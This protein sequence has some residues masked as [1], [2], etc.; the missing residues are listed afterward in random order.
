MADTRTMLELLQAPTEGYEDAIVIPAILA[1]NFELKVG[2]LQL[3][4]SSQFHD[5]LTIIENKSKVR[6]SR[7]KLIVS[8]VSTTTSSSSHSPDIIALTDIVKEL[9]LM[10]KANQ[11]ASVKAVDEIC[12]TRGG[13][14]PYYE[15][16]ATDSN[17]FI[18]F[19]QPGNL[20]KEV[21]D[22]VLKETQIIVL[23]TKWGHPVFLL[24]MCKTIKTTI[25]GQTWKGT[26]GSGSLPS[27]TVANPRGDLK[28]FTT[29]SGVSY[30]GPMI[31]PTP[32]PLSK[33][34]ERETEVIKDKCLALADLGA[35]I[36]LMPLSVWKKL[37]LPELTPTRM[38]L[39]LADRSVAHPK[40]LIDVHGEELTLRVNDEAI[41]FKVGHTSRY[42][43]NYYDEMVHQVNVIDVA[44]E[45]YAQEVLR[46]LDSSTS[47]NPT[48]SNPIIAS[49]SPSF[50]PF[51]GGDFIL[52]EIEACL[53]NDSIPSGIDDA[54]FDP[55]GNIRLL[56]KLLNDDPSSPL[57]PK[58]LN[59]EELKTIKS[60]I[61][62]PPKLELKD[63]P[64][65]LEYTFLEGTNKLPVII[66][67]ELKDEEKA[68]LLKVLKSHKRAIAWKISDIK[69]INPSF[70]IKLLDA[71]LI[72]LIP[73]S[74][75]VSPVHCVPKK[76]GMTVDKNEDNEL[77]PTRLVTGWRVCID[78]R[79]LND[80]TRKYHFP[81]PFMDQMLERL[82]GNK[83]Y[84][85]LDGFSGY[86][87]IP[88]DPEDQEKTTFT[89]PYMGRLFLLTLCFWF[90]YVFPPGTFQRCMMA[91]FHDMIE[92]TMKSWGNVK[93][94]NHFRRYTMKRAENLAVDHLSRLENPHQGD[95]EK[96]EINETFP[97]ETLGMITFHGDSSTIWFADI[98]NYHARDFIVKGMSSQQKKKF[99]KDVKHYFWDDPYLFRIC[100][101]QVIRRCVHGQKSLNILTACHNGPIG[102]QHGA[103]YTAKKVFDSGFYW[104]TIYRDAHDMVQSCDSCQRQGKISQKDEMPQNTIQ[105]CE[106]FDVWGIDFMGPFPYSRG[107]K[108]ILF[109]KSLFSRF[110]TPRA[111]ISDRGTHFCNDQFSKVML[112]YGVTHHL[113]T[114]YHPQTSGQVEVSNR[115]LKS[116]LERTV[117]E[118]QASWFDKLDDAL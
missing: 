115:G 82:A 39:E 50:T 90:M 98:A 32:S 80:A 88:I 100:A 54:D 59:F 57:P 43:R 81:L 64:S 114:A 46:F 67:K 28:A 6:T 113:S 49:S 37:S 95:L 1:E 5:A 44:C 73:D 18:C 22:T 42:S 101:D 112:K 40:A 117:G 105:V 9:V 71:G 36:N 65:H 14:H 4:T 84:C 55:E 20:N 41:T 109:L 23:A 33:E 66:L 96:K 51:E 10:N 26:R 2:L 60:S 3:V 116:I 29:R 8:K 79:K 99:F 61:D 77:I 31:P 108:Y 19:G 11:Q 15:C 30:D 38:T 111:I 25:V 72:Y 47:G 17:T 89:C 48:P 110:G 93:T 62:D 103:N 68:A 78:Y 92:E 35:S 86:F 56:E 76:G 34:E 74:P 104:L 85:F 52:E 53:S 102:G 21:P 13:P 70:F 118:K 94:K 97:L 24:R 83:Y 58:E 12:V 107:N 27:N 91:I 45:E 87:Q 7:N 69:G 63:L 16:L 106:I 75:W